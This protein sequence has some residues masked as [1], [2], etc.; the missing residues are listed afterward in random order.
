MQGNYFVYI[1]T[2]P[3]KT[4]LYVGMTNDLYSRMVE[5]YQ[6]RGNKKTYAGRYYCYNLLY[7]E[8]FGNPDHAIEREKEI[9]KWRRMKKENLIG[10]KNPNWD[11]Y[12]IKDL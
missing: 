1:T 5:H 3:R 12:N 11:F 2:N 10:S 8:R 7:F 9:K 6:K 4:A